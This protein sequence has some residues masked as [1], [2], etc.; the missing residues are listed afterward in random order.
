MCLNLLKTDIRLLQFPP[1][2]VAAATALQVISGSE[3][4]LLK[5]ECWS[6]LLGI[7]ADDK[8]GLSS[9]PPKMSSCLPR[10]FLPYFQLKMF[11]DRIPVWKQ[12][13]AES[14]RKLISEYVA[15]AARAVRSLPR[16]NKRRCH[17]S[18]GCD[19]G[20]PRGVVDYFC[21]SSN[22]SW[23]AAPPSTSSSPALLRPKKHRS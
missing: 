20:S 17:G 6:Q 12:E 2:V 18:R 4:P 1:S 21:L 15:P 10:K 5:E 13:N 9:F 16:Q 8:V 7:L 11:S 14:C 19:P 3:K 22:D 23:E